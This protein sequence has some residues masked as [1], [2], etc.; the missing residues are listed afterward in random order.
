[1]EQRRGRFKEESASAV[2]QPGEGG[3]E[4]FPKS[5]RELLV[6][7]APEAF[8]LVQQKFGAALANWKRV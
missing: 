8:E 4:V 1:M 2:P 3:K 5:N 6:E 7:G